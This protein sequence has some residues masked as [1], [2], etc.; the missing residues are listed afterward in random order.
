VSSEKVTE[1]G[2]ETVQI[3]FRPPPDLL[4]WIDKQ[5]ADE[6]RNR[7]NMVIRLL[8]AAMKAKKK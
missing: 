6:Q 3:G 1:S 5:C 4:A 7:A 8:T 2:G